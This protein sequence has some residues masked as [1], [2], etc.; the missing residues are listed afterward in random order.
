MKKSFICFLL[1]CSCLMLTNCVKQSA[2]EQSPDEALAV[3]KGSTLELSNSTTCEVKSGNVMFTRAI[4][5]ADT[6]VTLK[7]NGALEFRCGEKKDFFCDPNG[8]LSNNT[9][10][11]LLTK[12]DNTKPFTF[13]A[14]VTPE[15]TATGTY[16]AADL[17]IFSNDTLWQKFAFEQDERGMHRIVTVRTDGT[18]DDNNHD[19]VTAPSVYLKISSDGQTIASY[20]SLDKQMWQMVRL[21]KNSYPKEVWV[22]ICNQCPMEKGSSSLFEEVTLEQSSVGDFRSGE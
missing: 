3:E 7:E 12:V 4:N 19:V 16:N 21:Y 9:A 11:I 5:G 22:G 20:Y 6:L 18:S 2:K 10:P 17:F 13:T 15:F 14:K 1:L 8:E